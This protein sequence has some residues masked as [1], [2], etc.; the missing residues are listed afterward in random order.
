MEYV[1]SFNG[2][3]K[4]YDF[5]PFMHPK[6]NYTDDTI[7]TV[8]IADSIMNDRCPAESMRDW[9][10]RVLPTGN[11]GGYGSGFIKWQAAPTVQPP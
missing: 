5:Q 2:R 8:A 6:G 11:G 3:N 10:R 4:R 9:G 7:M 1:W